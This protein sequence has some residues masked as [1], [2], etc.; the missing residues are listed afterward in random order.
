MRDNTYASVDAPCS[1]E[2][3]D[4]LPLH[5]RLAGGRFAQDS[6][7]SLLTCRGPDGV[8]RRGITVLEQR[9]ATRSAA[10]RSH[11][12]HDPV[13]KMYGQPRSLTPPGGCGE[14]GPRTWHKEG[15]SDP[16]SE[17][18]TGRV[19]VL[20]P[21]LSRRGF[22]RASLQTGAIAGGGRVAV[23][24]RTQQ[25]HS[26][27][28]AGGDDR[29]GRGQRPSRRAKLQLP[30][31]SAAGQRAGAGLSGLGRRRGHARLS[32]L[33]EDDLPVGEAGAR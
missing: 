31:V 19:G 30:D 6:T 16:V 29:A 18:E 2:S 24:V 22:L 8:A 4:V 14:M 11:T 20:K 17:R 26:W 5:G 13:T 9:V 32:E 7:S 21:Y 1:T 33:P 12:P 25:Q 23:G 28:G 27:R 3:F 10:T 15:E